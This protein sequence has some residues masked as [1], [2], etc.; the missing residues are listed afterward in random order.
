MDSVFISLIAIVQT[1][2]LYLVTRLSTQIDKINQE[3]KNHQLD[4]SVHK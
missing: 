2:N 4:R 1:F 3:L